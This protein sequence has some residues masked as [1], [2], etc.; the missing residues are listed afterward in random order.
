[1]AF[2]ISSSMSDYKNRQH[3]YVKGRR[4]T[5][6]ETDA[7]NERRAMH[8]LSKHFNLK[9]V[10]FSPDSH[11]KVDFAALNDQ[12]EIVSLFEFK[13][14]GNNHKDYCYKS[15]YWLP[16]KKYDELVRYGIQER[17]AKNKPCIFNLF[18]CWGFNDAFLYLNVCEAQVWLMKEIEGG[19]GYHVKEKLN[20]GKELVYLVPQDNPFIK[21][22]K[23][24]TVLIPWK[25]EDDRYPW[26][27]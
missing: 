18:Y 16:C 12:G 17:K 11:C 1:M 23:P 10:V 20:G 22:I 19:L 26:T 27:T 21:S 5:R 6:N 9:I 25:N 3:P 13:K 2:F 4:T 7:E 14:R 24:E 15:G 8:I